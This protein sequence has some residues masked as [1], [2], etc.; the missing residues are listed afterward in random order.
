MMTSKACIQVH[1]NGLMTLLEVENYVAIVLLVATFTWIWIP[2]LEDDIIPSLRNE[3]LACSHFSVLVQL[4]AFGTILGVGMAL[5]SIMPP[6]LAGLGLST[7][8]AG[9]CSGFFEFASMSSVNIGAYVTRSSHLRRALRWLHGAAAFS[10]TAMMVLCYLISTY[11]H[12]VLDLGSWSVTKYCLMV[13]AGM[14]GISL[15]GLL[16]FCLQQGVYIAQPASE[17][18]V[19]GF[20]FLI[21]LALAAT[22]NQVCNSISSFQAS[23]IVFTIMVLEVVVFTLSSLKFPVKESFCLTG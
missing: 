5:Q 17:N 10:C 7:V 2:E 18:F 1:L 9:V 11:R 4:V 20:I 8:F 6:V 14:Q 13:V 16:P 19:S 23:T 22:L 3:C 12:A 21:A 15:M